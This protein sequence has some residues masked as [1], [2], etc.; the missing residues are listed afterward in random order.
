VDTDRSDAGSVVTTGS[1]VRAHHV[2]YRNSKL[3]RLL[4]RSLGGNAKTVLIVCAN[5]APEDAAETLSS[6]RFGQRAQ[7]VKNVVSRNVVL[8]PD[9][10]VRQLAKANE[11]L[12]AQAAVLESLRSALER[13]VGGGGGDGGAGALAAMLAALNA[14]APAAAVQQPLP[15]AGADADGPPAGDSPGMQAT[16]LQAARPSRGAVLTAVPAV[17]TIAVE[18][19]WLPPADARLPASPMAGGVTAAAVVTLDSPPPAGVV[20]L[21]PAPP[22]SPPPAAAQGIAASPSLPRAPVLTP[23]P[24]IGGGGEGRPD[25][26]TSHS[27]LLSTDTLDIVADML[28]DEGAATMWVQDLKRCAEKYRRRCRRADMRARQAEKAAALLA[29]GGGSSKSVVSPGTTPSLPAP[30]SPQLSGALPRSAQP[31]LLASP[32][33]ALPSP[34][35]QPPPL[36]PAGRAAAGA[37]PSSRPPGATA[38]M[39]APAVSPAGAGGAGGGGR[40]SVGTGGGGGVGGGGGGG[41]A[42]GGGGGMRSPKAVGVGGSVASA[43][44]NGRGGG[45]GSGSASGG[46][47]SGGGGVVYI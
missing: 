6:L 17:T 9:V 29:G 24:S 10:L 30:T 5:P 20:P 25:S 43:R 21:P 41:G 7:L 34:P 11:A 28:H 19:D 12:A 16:A 36:P 47:G 45:S 27:S 31:P 33:S 8:S 15:P 37:V 44:G 46:G 38:A 4:Q 35:S 2:P 1:R 13:M 26:P 32:V 18:G 23:T 14:A 3:T 40:L 42:G 22:P 39:A